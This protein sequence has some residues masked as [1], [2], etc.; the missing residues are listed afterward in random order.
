MD[1]ATEL[2]YAA[3]AQLDGS[4]IC[5]HDEEVSTAIPLFAGEREAIKSEGMHMKDLH[6]AH[7][8]KIDDMDACE[9]E[10][11]AIL[12]AIRALLNGH[13]VSDFMLSYPDVRAVADL[14][15]QQ[16]AQ[17]ETKP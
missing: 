15:N 16:K 10:T 11:E 4:V 14:I 17:K 6:A 9:I 2:R 5:N 8:I 12:E 3:V 13:E 7:K 1:K